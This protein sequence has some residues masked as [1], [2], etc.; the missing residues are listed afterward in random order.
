MKY[1]LAIGLVLL[2]EAVGA[3][4]HLPAIVAPLQN[5][6][7]IPGASWSATAPSLGPGFVFLA[8]AGNSVNLMNIGG[9]DVHLLLKSSTGSLTK[10]G[11]V[12]RRT[13]VARGITVIA[14]F[15]ANWVCPKDD[16]SCEV[17]RF[18]ATF[19]VTKGKRH[20]KVVGFGDV[21]S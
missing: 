9:R 18:S 7:A 2:I 13:F 3:S 1:L 11:D 16:D 17:T 19:D 5:Q 14:T 6:N 20:Q 21:G 10:V 8:E 4:A 12:M 15:K